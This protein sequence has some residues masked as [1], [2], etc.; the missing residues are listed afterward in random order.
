MIEK[1]DYCFFSEKCKKDIC[2]S[3]CGDFVELPDPYDEKKK[4]SHKILQESDINV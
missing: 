2:C 3:G 4:E 1:T